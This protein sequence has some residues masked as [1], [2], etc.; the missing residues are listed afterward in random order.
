[1]PTGPRR[2]ATAQRKTSRTAK[3]AMNPKTVVCNASYTALPVRPSIGTSTPDGAA[4]A[5]DW[6]AKAH[7]A[8]LR[9]CCSGRD[10]C[11]LLVFSTCDSGCL[12]REQYCE[13]D[14]R[15]ADSTK[16]AA[17]DQN[18]TAAC[19]RGHA[20]RRAT[21]RLWCFP[22]LATSVGT[23]LTTLCSKA[24]TG[25]ARLVLVAVVDR[26]VSARFVQV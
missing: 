14:S 1:M 21:Q 25:G 5:Q 23:F 24:C 10:I 3:H 2:L 13:V 15:C 4:R 6:C 17:N 16:T 8:L 9:A 18:T 20:G 7:Q 26:N 22:E 12:T 11:S 19:E